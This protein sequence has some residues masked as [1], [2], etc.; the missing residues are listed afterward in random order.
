MLYSELFLA[1]HM[2]EVWLAA[3]GYKRDFGFVISLTSA[4]SE[5][6]GAAALMKRADVSVVRTPGLTVQ[7]RMS[8]RKLEFSKVTAI[9]MKLHF[10]H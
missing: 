9:L 8:M 4:G 7:P 10:V 3:L 5:G 1:Y 6:L 2:C